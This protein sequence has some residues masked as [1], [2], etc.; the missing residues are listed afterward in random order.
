MGSWHSLSWSSGTLA[1][2]WS[3]VMM[4][5]AGPLQCVTHTPLLY[6]TDSEMNETYLEIC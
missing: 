4:L 5:S 1:T 6:E 2:L 3:V